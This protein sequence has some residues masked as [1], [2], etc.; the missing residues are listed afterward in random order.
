MAEEKNKKADCCCDHSVVSGFKLGFGIYLAFLAGNL[1][2][3]LIVIV[4]YY[5]IRALGLSF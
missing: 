2:L 4:I 1:I 5:L 3:A